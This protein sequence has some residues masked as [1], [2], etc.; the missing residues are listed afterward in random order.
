M[1]KDGTG[2]NGL[3]ATDSESKETLTSLET[4]HGRPRDVR[5][6]GLLENW[7]QCERFGIVGE[8]DLT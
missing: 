3:S 1:G 5:C 8:S 7:T 2:G 4:N 6:S